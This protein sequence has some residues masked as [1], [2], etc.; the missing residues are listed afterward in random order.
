MVN[1]G[2]I[3]KRI[4]Y[5]GKLLSPKQELELQ[6]R[7]K[8]AEFAR[9]K[10]FRIARE[11]TEKELEAKKLELERF[12]MNQQEDQLDNELKYLDGMVI[13]CETCGQ[14]IMDIYGKCRA[15]RCWTVNKEKIFE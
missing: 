11:K 4:K 3:L 5:D 1:W 7:Q 9:A 8:E 14:D 10:R 12:D 2:N 13:P 6:V 15:N